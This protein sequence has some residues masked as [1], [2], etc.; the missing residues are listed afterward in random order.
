MKNYCDWC[1]QAD[2]YTP[3]LKATLA[4]IK[5]MCC[6]TCERQIVLLPLVQAAKVMCVCRPTMREWINKQRV[7]IVR[8]ATGRALICYSSMFRPPAIGPAGEDEAYVQKL[9]ERAKNSRLHVC[10]TRIAA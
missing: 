7:N 6:A 4:V 9:S 1:H 8:T 3:P 10:Q 2:D 5:T